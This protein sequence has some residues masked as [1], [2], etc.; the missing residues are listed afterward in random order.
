MEQIKDTEM[1]PAP[2][3][4]PEPRQSEPTS[5]AEDHNKRGTSLFESEDFEGAITEFA[6]ASALDP[7]NGA[8]HCN[9]G[10]AYDESDREEEALA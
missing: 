10:M 2:K 8:Y 7:N 3:P 9:L 6:A 4:A 5:P 1:Q